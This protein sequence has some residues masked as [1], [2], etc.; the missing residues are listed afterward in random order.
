MH[1]NVQFISFIQVR[2]VQKFRSLNDLVVDHGLVAVVFLFQWPETMMTTK[3]TDE[4]VETT[5]VR[6]KVEVLTE[7]PFVES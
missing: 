2:S 4:V 7:M 5:L 6:M 1:M 3:E